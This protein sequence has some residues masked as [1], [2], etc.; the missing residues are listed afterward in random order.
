MQLHLLIGTNCLF[1]PEI[2]ISDYICIMSNESYTL[3]KITT[4]TAPAVYVMSNNTKTTGINKHLTMTILESA[5]PFILIKKRLNAAPRC[6]EAST[7]VSLL[8]GVFKITV[9]SVARERRMSTSV[10]SVS[11]QNSNTQHDE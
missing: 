3:C 11:R 7:S 8:M 9:L 10:I 6:W 4:V 5:F 2:T 1:I